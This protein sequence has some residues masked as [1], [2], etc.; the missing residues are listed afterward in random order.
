LTKNEKSFLKKLLSKER[1]KRKKMMMR[2]FA[3]NSEVLKKSLEI[4]FGNGDELFFINPFRGKMA[5]FSDSEFWFFS[6]L[7]KKKL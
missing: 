4:C 1:E 6:R 2:I 3:A 7:K 5:S